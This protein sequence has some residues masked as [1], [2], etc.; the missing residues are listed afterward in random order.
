VHAFLVLREGFRVVDLFAADVAFH[1]S[2]S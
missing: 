2:S 1:G